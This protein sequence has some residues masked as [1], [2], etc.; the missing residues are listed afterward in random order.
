MSMSY[1]VI[2]KK[3]YAQE[4]LKKKTE[5]DYTGFVDSFGFIIYDSY[6]ISSFFVESIL[7][8]FFLLL[9][10]L[11]YKEK[12]IHLTSCTLVLRVLRP[13]LFIT[14]QSEATF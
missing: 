12:Y 9:F 10:V 7:D 6:V 5:N 3:S 13:Y 14:S 1:P 2:K 4:I 11:Y 8:F